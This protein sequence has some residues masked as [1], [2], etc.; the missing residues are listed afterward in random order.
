MKTYIITLE[1]TFDFS[2]I[3]K[4]KKLTQAQYTGILKDRETQRIVLN[5]GNGY[6]VR[7]IDKTGSKLR[8]CLK[9]DLNTAK[10][11]LIYAKN[12][13]NHKVNHYTEVISVITNYLT[14]LK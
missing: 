3:S 5:K 13:A 10:N 6:T 14:L 2:I 7:N 8:K 9:A 11:Q 1:D 4:E 12:Y